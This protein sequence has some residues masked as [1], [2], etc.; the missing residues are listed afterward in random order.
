MENERIILG[1]GYVHVGEWD[2]N[3]VCRIHRHFVPTTICIRTLAA[4]Q[5]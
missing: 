3:A 5:H 4:A 2:K 1:S